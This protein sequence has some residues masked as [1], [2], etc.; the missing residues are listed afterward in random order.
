MLTRTSSSNIV[1]H[2]QPLEDAIRLQLIPSLT[3]HS[4]PGNDER[5]LL[6]LPP[7]LGGLDLVKPTKEGEIKQANS[8]HVTAPLVTR[9]VEQ[10]ENIQVEQ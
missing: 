10:D 5:V 1:K 9:I 2:L 7:R 4:P 6:G 8:Q 3:G